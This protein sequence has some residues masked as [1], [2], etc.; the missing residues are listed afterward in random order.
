MAAGDESG[1]RIGFIAY[2][3]SVWDETIRSAPWRHTRTPLWDTLGLT[4]LLFSLQEVSWSLVAAIVG[5]LRSHTFIYDRHV[6]KVIYV[7]RLYHKDSA[8]NLD[9]IVHLQG[10]KITLFTFCAQPEPSAIRGADVL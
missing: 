7:I 2:L 9:D 10:V 1:V 5:E 4:F 3:A 6:L 8:A